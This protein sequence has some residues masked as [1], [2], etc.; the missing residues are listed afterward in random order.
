MLN[1]PFFISPPYVEDDLL[2]T[3][4]V[5]G[6]AGLAVEAEFL[7]VV[8]L[9]LAGGVYG[10]VG[11]EGFQLILSGFDKHVSHKVSLPSHFHNEAYSHAGVFVG[12]AESVNHKEVLVGEFFLGKVSH[13]APHLFAHGVVVVFVFVGSPPNGVFGVLVHD[14]VFVFGRTTG[15][16][17]GHH[18]DGVQF[19]QLAFIVTGQRGI[20][21][22]LEKFFVGRIIVNLVSS[23]DTDLFKLLFNIVGHY[24]MF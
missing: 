9:G 4:D 15:V 11:R 2:T 14:N 23:G 3:A 10:E 8:H 12:T 18:V 20:H 22:H 6:H 16:D 5:E 13:L 21:L 19:G 17:A 24:L 1:I 7:V